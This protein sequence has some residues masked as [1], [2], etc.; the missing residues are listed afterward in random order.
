MAIQRGLEVL[1]RRKRRLGKANQFLQLGARGRELA[2]RLDVDRRQEFD[3]P[4]D[5]AAGLARH[6][7]L[8]NFGRLEERGAALL[9]GLSPLDD[10]VLP[11]V[12]DDEAVDEPHRARGRTRFHARGQSLHI[13]RPDRDTSARD[14]G[15]HGRPVHLGR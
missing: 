7:G 13:G 9:R 2:R 15:K 14:A 11:G 6:I 5:I 8:R 4:P 12:L 10:M 1:Q 3:D